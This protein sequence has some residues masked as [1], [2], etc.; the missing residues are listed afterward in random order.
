MLIE[1]VALLRGPGA[2]PG[3]AQ[4]LI[5]EARRRARRRRHRGAATAALLLA[6]ATAG[7]AVGGGG[8]SRDR[9]R[10]GAGRPSAAP[11]RP[12]VTARIALGSALDLAAGFGAVW[13]AQE[14]SVARVEG[15][16]ARLVTSIRTPTVGED[17]HIVAG[18]GSVWVTSGRDGGPVYR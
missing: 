16:D 3:G 8:A 7:Y 4:A 1:S 17:G 18:A 5:E 13:V 2:I 9:A 12:T 14:G 15:A 6:A 11:L 10:S